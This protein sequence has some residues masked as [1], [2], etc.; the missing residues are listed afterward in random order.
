M[1]WLERHEQKTS[2]G[3]V[4]NFSQ[5]EIATE[6]GSSPATINRWIQALQSANCV[7]QKKKGSYSI[8]KTG[9]AVITKMEEI[10]KILG[11]KKNG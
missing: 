2:R 6:Y 3:T 4:I 9:H 7:E 5:E 8:T 11:G 10:E 1:S